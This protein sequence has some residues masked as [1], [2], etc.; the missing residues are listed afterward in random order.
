MS[1]EQSCVLKGVS[2]DKVFQSGRNNLGT[3]SDERNPSATSP[4]TRDKDLDT[5]RSEGDSADG[6][7]GA[8]PPT[9]FV[10]GP[11]GLKEFIILRDKYQIPVHIPL[12]LS[13]K[14]EKCYYEGVEGVGVYDQMLK[15]WLRFSL[16]VFHYCLLQYLLLAVTQIAQNA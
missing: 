11:N 14:L 3:S 1:S 4:F 7:Y 2:Y 12:R 15:A 13:Y 10:I 9:Q 8:E 5:D 16:S 6:L